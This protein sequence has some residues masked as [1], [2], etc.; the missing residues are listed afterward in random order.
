[1]I[2]V[3][4]LSADYHDHATAHLMA[5][6]FES[7]DRARFETF[8]LSFGPQTNGAMRQRLQRSFD[9]FIDVQA[10]GE[11][12]IAALIRD[13]EIDIAVDLKGF[14]MNSRVGILARRPA[15]VHVNYLGYPGTMGADFIDYI[16]VDRFVVPPDRCDAFAEKTV[17]LP[18]TYFAT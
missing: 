10:E 12:T 9:R 5:G 6:V 11:L 14:T 15:P 18:D 7:H 13:L 3:A 17:Y 4:Y 16:L 1:R 8:A 2:R